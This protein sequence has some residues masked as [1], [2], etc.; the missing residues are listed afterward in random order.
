MEEW[1]P[2][3]AFNKSRASDDSTKIIDPSF[4]VS[5]VISNPG[6]DKFSYVPNLHDV[7]TILLMTKQM[8][9]SMKKSGEEGAVLNM[10]KRPELLNP[11]LMLR[12][13][14]KL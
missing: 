13:L 6:L 3:Y 2:Q 10:L 12:I 9:E 11:R 7:A 4:S 1:H 5:T 14:S 8:I